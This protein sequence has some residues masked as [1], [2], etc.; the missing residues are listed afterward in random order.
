MI[1]SSRPVV[2]VGLPV[3]NGESRVSSAVASVLSQTYQHFELVISDNASTDGT[4]QVC[5]ALASGDSRIVYHRQPVNLG[6]IG[7]FNA[8]IQLA[9][10][11]FF[12]WLGDDDH[13]HPEY[14]ERCVAELRSD[15][16]LVLVTTSTSVRD[17]SGRQH[18]SAYEG[19]RLGSDDPVFRLVEMLRW[20]NGK[21]FEIDPISAVFR[22]VPVAA[23]PM[24]NMLRSD[25][26]FAAELA[27]AGPWGHV[28]EVLAFTSYDDVKRAELARRLGVPAWRA[29]FATAL[30]GRELLRVV[31][32]SA[33]TAGERRTARAEIVR[34]YA[35]WHRRRIANSV[36]RVVGRV[37]ARF[38]GRPG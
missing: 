3:R 24:R 11:E 13:V 33:L 19:H 37:T 2:S 1:D 10:G 18:V 23:I 6:L 27:L 36:R 20:L 38:S 15:D 14:L 35:T 25:Q 32:E 22:R 12:C 16:R 34:W 31:A 7:N 21:P 4:E 5:R 8:V 30:E 17:P 28:A 29:R 9:R 26:L